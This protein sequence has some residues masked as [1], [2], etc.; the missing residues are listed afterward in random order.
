MEIF[1]I[2]I[3]TLV[4][5]SAIF[6]LIFDD[7]KLI[8][9]YLT[10]KKNFKYHMIR[11]YQKG[12]TVI[13]YLGTMHHMHYTFEDYNFLHLKAVIDNDKPDLLLIESRPEE[14][15][16]GNLAD[17][18][19]EMFYLHMHALRLGIPVKGIDYFN[20]ETNKPGTTNKV[21]DK[22]MLSLIDT[23]IKNH[24]QVLLAIGATHMLIHQKYLKRIGYKKVKVTKQEMDELYKHTD[25]EVLFPKEVIDYTK[26]RIERE[27]SFDYKDPK[28]IEAKP[29]IIKSLENFLDKVEQGIIKIEE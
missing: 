28:W 16:L 8:F 23:S 7:A 6:F 21:R 5:L 4:I 22:H 24:Q 26:V 25:K 12:D 20:E 27:K 15:E 17:G 9:W 10:S 18:P 19:I 11:R 1:L 29:R 2:I 14:L 13:T 3:G